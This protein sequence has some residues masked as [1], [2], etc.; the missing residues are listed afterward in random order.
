QARPQDSSIPH[1]LVDLENLGQ[2]YG[3]FQGAEAVAH[4]GA[5]PRPTSHTSDAVFRT[6]VL[7]T[8]NVF[9]AATQLGIRTIVYASSMSILGY[10]FYHQYFQPHYA[11]IDED[12]PAMPQDSYALSKHLGE[13]IAEA[14]TRR[15]TMTAISL[16]LAWIHT[17]ETFKALIPPLWDNPD[18]PEAAPGLWVYIDTR[19]VGQAF[20]LA[21]ESNLE[22]HHPFFI[23]A[24]NSF[25]KIPTAELMARYYPDTPIRA[26][27]EENQSL[28]SSKKAEATLGFKANY[29]WESYFQTE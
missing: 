17:P 1:R 26:G 12:H 18:A 16:R 24:P 25:M 27:L 7:S 3:A 5:I 14:F 21:L 2:V 20:R 11:P 6:N 15:F 19:D 28:I 4:L 9:E 8:Y 13:E 22:G 23:T 29:T 10:P